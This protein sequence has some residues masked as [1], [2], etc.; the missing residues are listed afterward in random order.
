MRVVSVGRLFFLLVALS[1]LPRI[2]FGQTASPPAISVFEASGYDEGSI[3]LRWWPVSL[4]GDEIYIERKGSGDWL[5]IARSVY[6]LNEYVDAGLPIGTVFSYRIRARNS[7]GLSEYSSEA[8]VRVPSGPPTGSP[9]APL[10]Q[11]E[12]VTPHAVPLNWTAVEYVQ[13]FSL[14]RKT[15][16]GDWV[17]I[18]HLDGGRI[19]FTDE[20]VFPST[21]YTY[22]VRAS[23]TYG[24]S[25]Y[26]SEVVVTTLAGP[27][28]IP[29]APDIWGFSDGKATSLSLE[30]YEIFNATGYLL[31]SK[32]GAD[33]VWTEVA[34]IFAGDTKFTHTNLTAATTYF[35]RLRAYNESGASDYSNEYELTTNAPPPET[36]ILRAT[37]L[38]YKQLELHW[39]DVAHDFF[40]SYI[41]EQK[42]GDSWGHLARL[43]SNTTNYLSSGFVASTEYSFRLMARNSAGTSQWSY[44]T[45]T[46]LPLPEVPPQAPLL[47]ADSVS[48]AEVRLKWIYVELVNEYRVERKNPAGAWE[49]I[50]ALSEYT[51]SYTNS[52][53]QPLTSYAYRIR[54]LN[55]HGSS[56]YSNEAGAITPQRPEIPALNGWATS[57][58]VVE[59]FWSASYGAER[60]TVE[61]KSTSGDWIV[62]FETTVEP[63]RYRDERLRSDTRYTYRLAAQHFSGEWFYSAELATKTYPPALFDPPQL[64]AT[65]ISST[66]ILLSW[67][68]LA[69]AEYYYLQKWVGGQWTAEQLDASVTNY[70]DEG[71]SPAT[72]YTY[73]IQGLNAAGP[74]LQSR[75]LTVTTHLPISGAI[76]MRIVGHSAGSLR[77]QLVGS[78]GQSFK[79]QRSA[80]FKSWTDA[81]DT[82]QLSGGME[83][84]IEADTN[85]ALSFYRTIQVE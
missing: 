53:L 8:T 70:L 20:L 37:V 7:S 52:G 55:S 65:A 64:S 73:R 83:V 26:S 82:L 11:I 32:V 13:G 38:S 66:A 30:W 36:P 84:D 16:S 9:E 3:F 79:I 49:E 4:I 69:H 50:A 15:G 22:R 19:S 54:A 40:T 12:N 81:T 59:L 34:N 63:F 74:S 85:A 24:N 18:M 10:L 61:R 41:L 80:D 71:L 14:E 48:H 5:E 25:P 35:Y 60:Y 28:A 1:V 51:T 31:E 76:M 62:L 2:A 75:L 56:P 21:T 77:V 72:S 27:P 23:N 39:N 47:Y 45:V 6:H 57:Q 42:W 58:S 44:V 33:G 29:R 17:V 43:G 46:T 78:T 68:P 67:E